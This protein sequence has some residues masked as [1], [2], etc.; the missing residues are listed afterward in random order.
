MCTEEGW[1]VRDGGEVG[2]ELSTCMTVYAAQWVQC[3]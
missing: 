3:G 1:G 2:Y